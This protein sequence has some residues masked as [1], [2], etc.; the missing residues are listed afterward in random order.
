MINLHGRHNRLCRP[1]TSIA[2][3]SVAAW[4]PADERTLWRGSAVHLAIVVG[5]LSH[6]GSGAGKSCT[7]SGKSP[8]VVGVSFCRL[9]HPAL[10]VDIGSFLGTYRLTVLIVHFGKLFFADHGVTDRSAL[11]TGQCD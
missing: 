8:L 4:C 11:A 2:G 3:S 7:G 9:R 6:T 1:F 10:N 5:V